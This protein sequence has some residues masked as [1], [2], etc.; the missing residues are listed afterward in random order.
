M[1]SG[2]PRKRVLI[3]GKF[4]D[5]ELPKIGRPTNLERQ[6]RQQAEILD[7]VSAGRS[8]EAVCRDEGMPTPTEFRRWVRQSPELRV[9][10][11]EARREYA[12]SLFDQMAD[13]AEELRTRAFERDDNATVTAKRAA[14]DALKHITARLAPA[15]YAEP[16]SQN[17]GVS[18]TV[19]TSLPLGPN[20]LPEKPI[21]TAFRV[22]SQSAG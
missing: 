22:I 12:H 13:L 2:K 10:W 4:R 9:A 17:Q 20:S 16:K 3:P 5:P 14:L 15:D 6:D 21:D 11:L 1:A 7:Q 19:V 18:V 8:L